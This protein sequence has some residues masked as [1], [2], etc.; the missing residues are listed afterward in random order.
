MEN[1]G[2]ADAVPPHL[3]QGGVLLG[4]CFSGMF[5][6]WCSTLFEGPRDD[7]RNPFRR[8]LPA[9]PDGADEEEMWDW[10]VKMSPLSLA[11]LPDVL[12]I[13]PF[14]RKQ[15]QLVT[16]NPLPEPA[17]RETA[18]DEG[19]ALPRDSLLPPMR[20]GT[21]FTLVL[22]L[23]ETLIHSGLLVDGVACDL[24]GRPEGSSYDPQEKL[25]H[26]FSL[27]NYPG[28]L[29][30]VKFRPHVAEVLRLL[31]KWDQCEVV[32]FTAGQQ[33]YADEILSALDPDRTLIRHRLYSHHCVFDAHGTHF[34]DLRALGR[35]MDR[36][37]L[38]DNSPTS[39]AM[40]PSNG[41]PIKSWLKDPDDREMW[42][43]LELV[44][45]LV[46]SDAP[47]QSVLE[48]R[49]NL[50]TFFESLRSTL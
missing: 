24:Y 28:F 3:L 26:I 47:V 42:H 32:L 34:K 6:V 1:G 33:E 22:D 37:A 5:G 19:H 2:R 39:L 29:C 36:I 15:F 27:Q 16:F 13:T 38:V 11:T 10:C 35:P 25:D 46:F 50:P 48:D 44:E 17:Q 31:S 8:Q 14:L 43:L 40:N 41:I 7:A 12:Q 20:P 4:L 9:A 49:Y 21:R 23:D 18:S 30:R 45:A